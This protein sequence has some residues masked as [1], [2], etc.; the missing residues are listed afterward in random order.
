M[1]RKFENKMI[2]KNGMNRNRKNQNLFPLNLVINKILQHCETF[3]LHLPPI[4]LDYNK[5]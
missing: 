1:R 4:I 3:E 5:T 2:L